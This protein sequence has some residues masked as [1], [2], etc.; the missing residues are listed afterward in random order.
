MKERKKKEEI[1]EG[2]MGKRGSG[3]PSRA[4]S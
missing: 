2:K 4:I 3:E 1:S